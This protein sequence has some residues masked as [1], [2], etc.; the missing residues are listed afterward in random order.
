MLHT[1]VKTHLA[2][3]LEGNGQQRARQQQRILLLLEDPQ[4]HSGRTQDEGEFPDLAAPG[5]HNQCRARWSGK[6]EPLQERE[7]TFAHDDDQAQARAA[8]QHGK[9]HPRD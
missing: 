6:E 4:G 8:L 9:A 5:S 7:H 3:F 2:R 1:R